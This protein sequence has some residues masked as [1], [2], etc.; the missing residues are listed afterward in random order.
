MRY[1]R[2]DIETYALD[3]D[4]PIIS[5]YPNS[6]KHMID[7]I[8]LHELDLNKLQFELFYKIIGQGKKKQY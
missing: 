4:T 6:C 2:T 5:N 3:L 7:E 8:N 1:Q